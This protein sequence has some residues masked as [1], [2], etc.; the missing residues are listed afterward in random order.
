MAMVELTDVLW[1]AIISF[2]T[3]SGDRE[4]WSSSL[5]IARTEYLI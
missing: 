2:A 1:C 4:F 5:T 3:T